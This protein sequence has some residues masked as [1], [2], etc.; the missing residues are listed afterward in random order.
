[1]NMTGDKTRSNP[2]RVPDN[3]FDEVN[4]KILASAIDHE[5]GRKLPFLKRFSPFLAAAASVAVL[6][7]AGYL[8]V[9]LVEKKT[10][11]PEVSRIINSSPEILLY[12][13][14][15]VTLE[16]SAA[17]SDFE[18]KPELESNEII[19]YLVNEGIEISMIYEKL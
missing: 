10:S 1:M 19:D 4:R 5:N 17:I 12:E 8:S 9:R 7:T 14:D 11:S 15:L 13:L 6:I 2:F 3:Y 16:N 18:E